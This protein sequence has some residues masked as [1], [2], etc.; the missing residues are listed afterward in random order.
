MDE[1]QLLYLLDKFYLGTC[2]EEEEALLNEWFRQNEPE[3]QKWL[4]SE[5]GEDGV[6]NEMY[7]VFLRGLKNNKSNTLF[8][9]KRLYI[10]SSVAAAV[11][12][13]LCA[14]L[15][16][17]LHRTSNVQVAQTN[18]VHDVQPGRDGAILTLAN[19]RQIVLDSAGNS[20]TVMSLGNADIVNRN[21][22]IS[23][24][25]KKEVATKQITYNTLSTPKARQYKIVLPDGTKVWLNAASELRYPTAFTGAERV[26]ELTGEAYFNVVH[27]AE[28]PFKVKA[29]N[30]VIEDIGTVF[31]INSYEDEPEVK[32]TLLEGAVKVDGVL[33]HPGEQALA[34]DKG[35]VRIEKHIDIRQVTAWQKGMFEFD[36]TGLEAIMRQISRWYDVDIV[37]QKPPGSD[38]FG[39]GIN[40]NQPLSNVL[41][42]LEAN[43]VHFKLEGKTLIVNPSKN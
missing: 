30:K 35:E 36:N 41:K 37:Y 26:V 27:N 19:G 4:L 3:E 16:V 5:S 43:G 22:E 17:Y 39:G 11:L 18:I 13:F 8:K 9:R 20:S 23:Y 29:G 21:G 7:S 34:D 28:Q 25:N 6:A 15:Y 40:K 12:L 24:Y 33:L 2:T 1:R 10:I 32:T 31:D 42:L 14:G 38:A